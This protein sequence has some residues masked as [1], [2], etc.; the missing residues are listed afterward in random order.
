MKFQLSTYC[1]SLFAS[2]QIHRPELNV[3]SLSEVPPPISEIYKSIIALTRNTLLTFTNLWSRDLRGDVSASDWHT[4]FLFTH[5]SSISDYAQEKKYKLLF[6]WY[7]DRASIKLIYPTSTDACW[8]CQMK[9][10]T[11]LVGIRPYPS[12]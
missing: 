10:G 4:A 5:K 3:K 1:K 11:Y 12:F 7:R 9:R 6:R 2:N 8:H